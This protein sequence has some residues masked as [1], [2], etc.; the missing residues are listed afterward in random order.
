[1]ATTASPDDI[2]RYVENELIQKVA[3]LPHHLKELQ[4]DPEGIERKEIAGLKT[5]HHSTRTEPSSSVFCSY[6]ALSMCI[7]VGVT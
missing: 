5:R 7:A 6:L 1:M 3:R 4:H 2:L